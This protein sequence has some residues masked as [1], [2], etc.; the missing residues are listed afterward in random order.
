M[1]GITQWAARRVLVAQQAYVDSSH[2]TCFTQHPGGD[3]REQNH[4]I[5][6]HRMAQIVFKITFL[7]GLLERLER[8]K[9]RSK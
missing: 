7:W 5:E 6:A 8:R 3:S 2:R 9:L 4:T 1:I